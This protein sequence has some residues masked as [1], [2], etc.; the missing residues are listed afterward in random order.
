M[1]ENTPCFMTR[2]SKQVCA[3]VDFISAEQRDE[4]AAGNGKGRICHFRF[5][6]LAQI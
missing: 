4:K 6:K 3:M 5:N 2:Q 1:S